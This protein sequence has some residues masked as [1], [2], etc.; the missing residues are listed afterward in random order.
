MGLGRRLRRSLPGHAPPARPRVAGGGPEDRARHPQ[1]LDPIQL[2]T[3][4]MQRKYAAAH[5]EDP[6]FAE[7][8][9]AILFR[10]EHAEAPR[11]RVSLASRGCRSHALRGGSPGGIRTVVETYR[12]PIRDPLGVPAR[13][14][15]ARL[16]RPVPDPARRHQPARQRRAA[17]GSGGSVTVSCTT[18]RRRAS[19]DRG[20][21]RR[22]GIPPGDRDAFSS[23]IFR[24][25]G[26]HGIGA[27]RS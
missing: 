6:V 13:R 24:P 16:V 25:G 26:G 4:R 3:E 17:L 2:S 21:G 20:R 5:A 27:S 23:R 19:A 1:S 12:T 18:T 9:Q 22:A 15:A 10:G 7:C 8:T 14:P 11:R